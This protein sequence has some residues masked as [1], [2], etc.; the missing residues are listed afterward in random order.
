[1][2][3]NTILADLHSTYFNVI[4]IEVLLRLFDISKTIEIYLLVSSM[5]AENVKFLH[6]FHLFT[7]IWLVCYIDNLFKTKCTCAS[8]YCSNV[9]FL[10]NVMKEEIS[11][12]KL[13]LHF[14]LYNQLLVINGF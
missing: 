3:W 6:G 4:R 12:G 9:V 8:N 11:F 5:V 7:I 14:L 13:F 1:M 2:N 10:T